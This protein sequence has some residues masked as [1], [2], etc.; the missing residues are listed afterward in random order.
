MMV[1]S[2][3][4]IKRYKSEEEGGNGSIWYQLTSKPATASSAIEYS[5]DYYHQ[6]QVQ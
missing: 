2:S 3:T 4:S 6:F 1:P 5:T